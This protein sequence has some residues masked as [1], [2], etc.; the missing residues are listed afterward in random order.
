MSQKKF[1][2]SGRVINRKSRQGIPN[3]RVEVWD[4][5]LIFNDLVGNVVTR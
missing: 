5:D 3:L 4:K 2:I 1:H